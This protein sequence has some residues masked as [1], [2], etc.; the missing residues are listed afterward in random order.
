MSTMLYFTGLFYATKM[1]NYFITLT[2]NWH[3][4]VLVVLRKASGHVDGHKRT[5][6]RPS[7]Q[8][9]VHLAF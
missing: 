8:D 3:H 4:D 1:E 6:C 9:Q 2:L 7:T 5:K